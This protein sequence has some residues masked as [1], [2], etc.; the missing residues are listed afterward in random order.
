MRAATTQLTTDFLFYYYLLW[1]VV[2]W[3]GALQRIVFTDAFPLSLALLI[4][5]SR[6]K[7]ELG[8]ALRL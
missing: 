1:G 2:G 6:S 4:K 7:K 3:V 8:W 5:R